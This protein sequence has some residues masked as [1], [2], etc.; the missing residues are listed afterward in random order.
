MDNV[1]EYALNRNPLVADGA[2]TDL[3]T[4]FGITE[5]EVGGNTD[6]Y[7]S[8]TFDFVLQT[9]DLTYDVQGADNVTFTTNAST[10]VFIDPPYTGNGVGAGS[11]TG[12]GG[13]TSDPLV[14][15]AVD[16]GYS[17]RVTVRDNVSMS[18]APT[19]FMRVVI[20]DND[21]FGPSFTSTPITMATEAALYA[22]TLTAVDD[23]LPADPDALTYTFTVPAWITTT[24]DNDDGTADISGT[25]GMAEI[26]DHSVIIDV[27][28][29][30][31]NATQTFTITVDPIIP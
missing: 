16:N 1:L 11:L 3:L 14:L 27:S 24:D 19:R 23:E 26:G 20:L 2:G 29:G 25:P 13:L 8:L 10:L 28:D 30:T 5:I 6:N 12:D 9:S 17:A 18:A 15:A 31:H 4:S 21:G 22:Y 7:L